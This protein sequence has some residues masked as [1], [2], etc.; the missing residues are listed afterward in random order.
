M[1]GILCLYMTSVRPGC[2][3]LPRMTRWRLLLTNVRNG[4]CGPAMGLELEVGLIQI[5]DTRN[6]RTPQSASS[7]LI[8]LVNPWDLQ[9]PDLHPKKRIAKTRNE[10]GFSLMSTSPHVPVVGSILHTHPSSPRCWKKLSEKAVPAAP[11]CA[12]LATDKVKT[13]V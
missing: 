8:N 11:M 9:R 10:S 3:S 5:L 6:P 13:T 2:A 1:K 12:A 4:V 7:L